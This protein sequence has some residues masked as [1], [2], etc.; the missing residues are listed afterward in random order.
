MARKDRHPPERPDVEIGASVKADSL[1]FRKKPK[2]EV[3]L[4]GEVVEPDR[5]H[6]VDT[7]SGSERENLP[8]E[9]EPG[10]T[11]RDVSVRWHATARIEDDERE[12]NP[13]RRKR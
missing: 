10:V 8:D 4:H 1:R 2:T 11:Y 5:R 13:E 3:E 6:D 9:V 12:D 7:S